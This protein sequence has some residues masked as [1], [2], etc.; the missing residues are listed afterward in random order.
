MTIYWLQKYTDIL[1]SAH[2]WVYWPQKIF[3][4]VYFT[5]FF[6][7][8]TTNVTT[9]NVTRNQVTDLQTELTGSDMMGIMVINGLISD[10]YDSELQ[11]KKLISD[12]TCKNH[13]KIKF[14]TCIIFNEKSPVRGSWKIVWK[15]YWSFS[16]CLCSS[17]HCI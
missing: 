17:A 8:F 3:I 1:H 4:F 6:N 9:I 2:R 10:H 13:F 11:V 7:P 5:V 14:K 12:I 15:T 16:L